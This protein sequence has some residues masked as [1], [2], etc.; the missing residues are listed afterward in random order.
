VAE[1]IP[2][3]LSPYLMA[4]CPH[5]ANSRCLSASEAPP[6]QCTLFLSAVSFTK[7]THAYPGPILS[8]V[9]TKNLVLSASLISYMTQMLTVLRHVH[10]CMDKQNGTNWQVYIDEDSV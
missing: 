6:F 8:S 7:S 1:D 9:S 4:P 2:S 10:A 5:K 3:D